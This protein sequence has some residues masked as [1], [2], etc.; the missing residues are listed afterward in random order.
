M[1]VRKRGDKWSWYINLAKIDG[2][3]RRK[4]KGGYKTK[5]EAELALIKSQEEYESCGKVTVETNMSM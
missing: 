4:E 1:S 3:R 2:K 5:K